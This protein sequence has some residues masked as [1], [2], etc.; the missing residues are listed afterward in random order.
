MNIINPES[1]GSTLDALNDA[2]FFGRTM[3]DSE[4]LDVARWIGGR[5]GLPR[6]YAGM[7]APT[8]ADFDRGATMFTGEVIRTRAGASH[9]LGEEACRALIK[10]DVPDADVRQSLKLAT[11]GI[12]GRLRAHYEKP[13]TLWG[14]YCCGKCTVSFWRHLAVGG[15]DEQK[16]RLAAGMQ[17]LKRSRLGDGKWRRFPFYYTLLA[18]SEVD[19]PGAID[20]MRYAAPVC[21][22]YLAR[23]SRP[24]VTAQRR[25][26]VAERVL[27]RC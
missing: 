19:L 26:A 21:E 9:I 27:A 1:L 24:D 20:E 18:L 15:L 11:E 16:V 7:F 8:P 10:L 12:L 14:T 5:Q 6:A 25:R 4:K 13:G 23:P 22:R 17:E 2:L 3:S